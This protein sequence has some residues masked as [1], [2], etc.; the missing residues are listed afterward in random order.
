MAFSGEVINSNS[1]SREEVS[2]RLD[3]TDTIVSNMN[4]SHS[5]PS[6][7]SRPNYRSV[8]EEDWELVRIFMGSQDTEPGYP[9]QN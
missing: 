4:P 2:A 1:I 6:S 3:A 8:T 5:H 7:N 9:C